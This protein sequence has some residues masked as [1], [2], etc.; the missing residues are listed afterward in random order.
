MQTRA[1]ATG[2]G[3]DGGTDTIH[4]VEINMAQGMWTWDVMEAWTVNM[5]YTMSRAML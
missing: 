2:R 1:V 3:F 4:V 5:F